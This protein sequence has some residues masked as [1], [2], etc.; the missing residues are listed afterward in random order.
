MENFVIYA[1]QILGLLG[2]FGKDWLSGSLKK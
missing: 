2:F 1:V